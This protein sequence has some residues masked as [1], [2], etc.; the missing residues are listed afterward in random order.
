MFPSMVLTVLLLSRHPAQPGVTFL[1]SHGQA[2]PA[3]RAPSS[4]ESNHSGAFPAGLERTWEQDAA[5]TNRL[6]Q[7]LPSRIL[8][9][10]YCM[11]LGKVWQGGH[12]GAETLGQW[13][14][15]PWPLLSCLRNGPSDAHFLAVLW[16]KEAT[17]TNVL[18]SWQNASS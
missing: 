15:F 18:V 1:R 7:H 6:T 14:S 4:L 13:L 11:R 9:S 10:V 3:G 5:Q 2:R 12:I 17:R 8:F 16:R